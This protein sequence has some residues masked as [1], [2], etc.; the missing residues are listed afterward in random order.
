[1]E[2]FIFF[3]FLLIMFSL[4]R[5]KIFTG[6]VCDDLS[7]FNTNSKLR[8]FICIDCECPIITKDLVDILHVKFRNLRKIE[9]GFTTGTLFVHCVITKG[10]GDET[11]RT[12]A[13]KGKKIIKLLVIFI[14]INFNIHIL[15][16]HK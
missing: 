10:A 16:L 1:M 9:F 7:V 11:L 12:G 13:C 14:T 5:G 4:V 2:K 8:S 3:F 6:I 15:L